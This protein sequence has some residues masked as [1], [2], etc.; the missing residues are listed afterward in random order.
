[1]PAPVC[2][3]QF[4]EVSVEVVDKAIA[5]HDNDLLDIPLLDIL[6]HSFDTPSVEYSGR[7]RLVN[8]GRIL[9]AHVEEI[10]AALS[11]LGMTI[12]TPATYRD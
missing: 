9:V 10:R 2:N 3:C 7:R 12:P 5:H 8:W 4:R 11:R 6:R 1:M